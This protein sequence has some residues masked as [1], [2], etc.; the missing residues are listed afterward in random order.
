M[1]DSHDAEASARV[2]RRNGVAV[3]GGAVEWGDGLGGENG[4]PE[5]APVSG[6]G[7]EKLGGGERDLGKNSGLGLSDGE[8]GSE[9]REEGLGGDSEEL[10]GLEGA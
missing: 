8:H 1:D 6:F 5:D 10:A 2:A 9:F 4:L 3:H 7:S